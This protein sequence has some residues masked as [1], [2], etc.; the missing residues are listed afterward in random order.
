MTHILVVDD[1]RAV[2]SALGAMLAHEELDVSIA[3][4]GA[5]AIA[6]FGSTAFDVVIVDMFMRGA[7][8]AEIIRAIRRLNATVP[9]IAMTGFVARSL[10]A[11][12]DTVLAHAVELGAT[13]TLE[14]PLNRLETIRA[15]ISC[16]GAASVA[17]RR[18]PVDG[19]LASP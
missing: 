15:V 16:L 4:D 17:S 19:P 18:P 6:A 7:D 12:E 1:N 2:S 14:K 5:A 13:C 3:D 11:G 8:G 10:A 9:I